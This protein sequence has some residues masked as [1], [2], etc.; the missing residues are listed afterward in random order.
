MFI[1]LPNILFTYISFGQFVFEIHSSDRM[2]FAIMVVLIIVTQSIFTSTFLPVCNELLWMNAFNLVSM[3][4][5]LVATLESLTV[6]KIHRLILSKRSK[7]KED[8]GKEIEDEEKEEHI[9]L[10]SKDADDGSDSN[11]QLDTNLEEGNEEEGSI[12]LVEKKGVPPDQPSSLP[13]APDIPEA[14]HA[15]QDHRPS[16]TG[17]GEE[18]SFS[19]DKKQATKT[20]FKKINAMLRAYTTKPKGLAEWIERLDMYCLT[21]FTT[22][23]SI[24]VAV[25]FSRNPLWEDEKSERW[26]P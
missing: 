19:S 3:L 15:P 16:S 10:I 11:A 13:G 21:M 8:A 1:L 12:A 2:G 7:N 6:F 26:M 20:R 4:F 5:S 9:N 18:P 14:T 24:F 22:A 17:H 23:Y 25:M